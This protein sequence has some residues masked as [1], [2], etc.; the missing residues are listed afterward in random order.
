MSFGAYKRGLSRTFVG[1]ERPEMTEEE[2]DQQIARENL[3]RYWGIALMGDGSKVEKTFDNETDSNIWYGE[4]AARGTPDGASDEKPANRYAATWDVWRQE[5]INLYKS[6]EF[7]KSGRA[8]PSPPGGSQITITTKPEEPITAP[9]DE[10]MSASDSSDDDEEGSGLL[11][12]AAAA[13]VG[14]GLV[15]ATGSKKRK[16]VRR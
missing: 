10:E 1:V 8:D 11:M 4:I 6:D 13:L 5:I 3:P 7:L 2:I 9:P 16:G 15:M 14:V 12:G